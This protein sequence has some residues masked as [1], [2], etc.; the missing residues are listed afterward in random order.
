MVVGQRGEDPGGI[1]VE[2]GDLRY[3]ALRR[4]YNPR[5]YA[6]PE[7]V[8]LVAS[9]HEAKEA[10]QQAV[11]EAGRASGEGAVRDRIT[12]RSGGHCYENFVC[13]ED[14]RVIIDVSLMDGIYPDPE[15]DAICVEAG[16]TNADLRKRLFLKTGKVLPGGSCA[17]VG[18]GG[19]VPAGG[20]GLLSRQFGLTVDYLY[21]VEVAVVD[22][23]GRVRLVTATADSVGALGDLWWAHTGGGGGNFGVLTRLWF[24]RLPDA[25]RHVLLTAGGW[26]WDSIGPESFA[27]IIANFGGFFDRHRGGEDD[28]FAALFG[29]LLLTHR[30][31]DTIGLI[32][33]L[34]AGLP[35][36]EELMAR[37]LKEVG[38][39]LGVERHALTRSYGEY[40]AL[41]GLHAPTPLPWD[42]VDKLFGGTDNTRAGKH[43]SAYMR[44]PLPKRHVEALWTA[45]AEEHP[46]ITRDAVVQ[47]DS[48]GSA[49]NRVAAGETAVSQ[50]DSI[51]K[52]QHQVYWPASVNGADQLRWI[53]ELY[54]DMYRDTGGVPVNAPYASAPTDGCYIGYPEVDLSDPVWNT[55]EVPWSTLYYG[56]DYAR[57]QDAKRVWDPRNVFRHRQ[58]V[59]I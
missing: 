27:Q 23:T 52:L 58:S 57:L 46:A 59:R 9:P 17:T 33:Q 32:A 16:A 50:R 19:H 54:R 26:K 30:S 29:I 35:H 49:I 42:Q 11:D 15:M 10:L 51:L 44:G 28:P 36:A 24:R 25:P 6:D 34:D 13:S 22:D 43:K 2:P 14:V 5:W 3:P 7:Y 53:R 4:G 18:V 56:A 39:D 38:R 12:V 1:K 45:L 48:Y 40:P 41:V 55:S 20:F 21:A 8:R 47:I 37:F 31:Q